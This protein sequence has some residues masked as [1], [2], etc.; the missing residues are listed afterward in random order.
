[1]NFGEPPKHEYSPRVMIGNWFEE[2]L[3]YLKD[4]KHR[5]ETTYRKNFT[6]EGTLKSYV[7]DVIFRR[8][9]WLRNEGIGSELIR[10][11]R[12]HL[13]GRFIT[14]YDQ[15]FGNRKR[16]GI[17]Y[18]PPLRTWSSRDLC[19]KPEKSDYPIIGSPT[20]WGLL[21]KKREVWKDDRREKWIK[22]F[23][24]SYQHDYTQKQRLDPL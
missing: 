2:R 5:I 22:A 24:S 18:L 1:M 13:E 23:K 7:P 20:N 14:S 4:D 21:E 6:G 10:Q 8:K 17:N 3:K 19:W 15:E 11:E 16:E 9:I 12:K